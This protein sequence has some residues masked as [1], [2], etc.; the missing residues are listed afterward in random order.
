MAISARFSDASRRRRMLLL[1][2]A[3]ESNSLSLDC[4]PVIAGFEVSLLSEDSSQEGLLPSSRLKNAKK[5]RDSGL[6]SDVGLPPIAAQKPALT[7]P[8]FLRLLTSKHPFTWVFTGDIWLSPRGSEGGTE[9]RIPGL[10]NSITNATG[11]KKDS[12]LTTEAPQLLV[13]D[14][15]NQ[16][17]RR[18][19][20]FRP[21]IAVYSFGIQEVLQSEEPLIAYEK[22]FHYCANRL[23][24]A[25]VTLIV[26]L[27]H[28]RE[29]SGEN[30]SLDWRLKLEA[31]RG[32][33]LES[34]AIVI[35]HWGYWE[36]M[37][38]AHW[39]QADGVTPSEIG[40]AQ[41]AHYFLR[42]VGLLTQKA[43]PTANYM[44]P[45]D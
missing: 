6:E 9:L 14:F 2:R 34:S 1:S 41:L 10:L 38:E 33:A 45:V 40:N 39:Y 30:A 7:I 26:N 37:A 18:V 32:C 27:P 16:L 22:R 43:V 23:R 29:V 42:E 5:S 44:L 36:E 15:S 24:Q 35:D 3:A 28:Y 17:E 19:L 4:E 21:Q 12:Y 20:K 11:R 31:I 25:G 8:G 13:S